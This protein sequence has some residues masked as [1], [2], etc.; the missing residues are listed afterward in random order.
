MKLVYLP[1][2]E[3]KEENGGEDAEDKEFAPE[4]IT[5]GFAR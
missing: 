1:G 3:S 5:V 2:E 4:G